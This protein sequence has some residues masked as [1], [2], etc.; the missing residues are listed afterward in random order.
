LGFYTLIIFSFSSVRLER[1]FLERVA[2]TNRVKST[3]NGGTVP[4]PVS[5][6]T[7]AGIGT[8]EDDSA[9]FGDSNQNEFSHLSQQSQ[10]NSQQT[11]EVDAPHRDAPTPPWLKPPISILNHGL[12]HRQNSV[13][14]NRAAAVGRALLNGSLNH[15]KTSTHNSGFGHNGTLVESKPGPPTNTLA[16]LNANAN[17]NA[18]ASAALRGLGQTS[19]AGLFALAEMQRRQNMQSQ[20]S[21]LQ[22]LATF[23]NQGS[24]QG[25]AALAGT[26]FS[27]AALQQ[28]ARTTSAARLAGLAASTTSMSNLLKAGLSRDQLSQLARDGHFASTHSLTNMMDRQSSFDALMSLDFQSLQSIVSST[29]DHYSLCEV[30]PFQLILTLANFNRIT[31]LT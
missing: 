23:Q 10:S 3:S 18:N 14:N 11:G 12:N 24:A 13:S 30:L 22:Q 29:I 25:L 28:L 7:A 2:Q 1:R 4:V 8:K 20:A 6:S 19:S 31:W 26:G 27:S 9:D 5:S 16:E 21:T 17:A 15:N